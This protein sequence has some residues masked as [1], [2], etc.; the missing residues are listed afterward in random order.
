MDT[1]S[2]SV[3]IELSPRVADP[4][5]GSASITRAMLA[6]NMIEASLCDLIEVMIPGPQYG[7]AAFAFR[8]QLSVYRA[9]I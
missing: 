1:L 5:I 9:M 7:S 4:Q 8:L 2:V 6:R 3:E